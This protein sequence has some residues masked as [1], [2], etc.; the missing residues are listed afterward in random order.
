LQASL[1]ATQSPFE[2]RHRAALEFSEASRIGV[3]LCVIF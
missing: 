1:Q 2:P 3:G